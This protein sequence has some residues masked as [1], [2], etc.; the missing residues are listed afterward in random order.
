[1]PN[2]DSLAFLEYQR[3]IGITVAKFQDYFGGTFYLTK[4]ECQNRLENLI[5]RNAL[6]E[7]T[8][9]AIDGW[10]AFGARETNS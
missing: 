7:E 5:S 1:M 9:R 10:P 8:R 3:C 4:K 2:Q 6:H